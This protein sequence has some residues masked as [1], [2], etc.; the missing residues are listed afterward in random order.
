MHCREAFRP[1]TSSLHSHSPL[2]GQMGKLRR[3]QVLLHTLTHP[4]AFTVEADPDSS[5]RSSRI[6]SSQSSNPEFSVGKLPFFLFLCH[7]GPQEQH[8]SDPRT[9]GYSGL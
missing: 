3:A 6:P 1:P 8:L 5:H 2:T 4:G 9:T 7:G